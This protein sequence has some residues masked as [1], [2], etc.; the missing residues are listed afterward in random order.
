MQDQICAGCGKPAAFQLANGKWYC[1]ASYR[2]CPGVLEKRRKT[3]FKK[4]G[5]EHPNRNPEVQASRRRHNVE[6]YGVDHPMK[7]EELQNQ[8]AKTNQIRYGVD[9]PF[10][11]KA[12][13]AK[14]KRTNLQKY[15]VENPSQNPDV[16][17]RREAT[18]LE[19]YGVT[20]IL[21]A[22]AT[23]VKGKATRL[24]KYGVE[25]L[26]QNP[27]YFRI[28]QKD[29]FRRKAVEV[30][31]KTFMVQGAEGQV[32][33]E[34][35]DNG[36]PADAIE[37]DPS[38]VPTIWYTKPNGKRARY[39]PDIYIPHRNWIV[40]VKSMYTFLANKETNLLKRKACIEAGY[41]FNFI[42]R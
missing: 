12:I 37:T 1:T 8:V 28:M 31:G 23:H 2:A 21:A 19:K 18:F 38:K 13:Q 4:Y 7:A 33:L 34:L 20:Q 24:R 3:Y 26:S 22:K 36:F 6:K 42:I 35:I 14:I 39:Y 29:R 41:K 32:L 30:G 16:Q 15:G 9:N 40:E 11:A 25:Y 10:A 27:M 5:T 17:A